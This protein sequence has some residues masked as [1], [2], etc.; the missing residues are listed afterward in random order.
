MLNPYDKL[1]NSADYIISQIVQFFLI[2]S[3]IVFR[4][5][6]IGKFG[7]AAEAPAAAHL[8]ERRRPP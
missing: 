1:F 4:I 3:M 5:C 6:L 2:C 8:R 7:T